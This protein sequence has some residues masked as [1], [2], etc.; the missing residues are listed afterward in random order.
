[1]ARRRRCAH[2]GSLWIHWPAG[3]A[4]SWCSTSA[5][6]GPAPICGRTAM[7]RCGC[8]ARSPP[9]ANRCRWSCASGCW[10]RAIWP[11]MA[12]GTG[13]SRCACSWRGRWGCFH[14]SAAWTAGCAPGCLPRR[15]RRCWWA[16]AAGSSA[17]GEWM[18]SPNRCRCSPCSA[19]CR[20]TCDWRAGLTADCGWAW[21]RGA[22][23]AAGWCNCGRC[24][25][26]RAA[27]R[28][29]S[30]A[31]GCRCV[32]T[33]PGS[34]SPPAP[35]ATAVGQASSRRCCRRAA[36]CQF[37]CGRVRL[38]ALTCLPGSCGRCCGAAGRTAPCA[39]HGWI[40]RPAPRGCRRW[41]RWAAAST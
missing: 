27:W 15:A 12:W 4:G 28:A 11:C 31:S 30:R 41:A 2:C 22:S 33:T 3:G 6:R 35:G 34:A 16:A 1:M 19:G 36:P 25:G 38:Q 7:A 23:A 20:A 40:W 18:W 21:S 8:W 29:R 32:A 10:N 26:A 9:A 37:A 24:A 13:R 39:A 14:A 17:C 5:W